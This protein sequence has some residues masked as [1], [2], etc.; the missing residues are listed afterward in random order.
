[1]SAVLSCKAKDPLTLVTQWAVTRVCHGFGY[2]CGISVTGVTV[3][4]AV[5]DFAALQHTV[6]DLRYPQVSYR[7]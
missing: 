7:Y 1:M 2:H 6:T 3:S 5:S 4:G